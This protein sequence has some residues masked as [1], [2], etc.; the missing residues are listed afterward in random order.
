MMSVEREARTEEKAM[1]QLRAI[2]TTDE[3]DADA[4]LWRLALA[5]I[6]EGNIEGFQHLADARV[7]LWHSYRINGEFE[8]AEW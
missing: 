4:I 3:R 2:R 8:L 1:L 6:A 5:C 7:C